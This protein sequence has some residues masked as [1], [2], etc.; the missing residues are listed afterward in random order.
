MSGNSLIPAGLFAPE[1]QRA[2]E[3]CPVC[4]PLWVMVRFKVNNTNDCPVLGSQG[5]RGYS[6]ASLVTQHSVRKFCF[7]SDLIPPPS[8]PGPSL[9]EDQP[10]APY[11]VLQPLAPSWGSEAAA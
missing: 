9:L 4:P 5:T 2:V 6:T 10:R 1:P 3:T 11:S 7:M 8:L